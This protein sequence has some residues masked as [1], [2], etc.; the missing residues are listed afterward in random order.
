[1]LY[2]LQA[3]LFSAEVSRRDL[4][5]IPPSERGRPV[6]INVWRNHA[7]EAILPLMAPFSAIRAWHGEFNL[8]AYDDTL[9]F[10]G[11]RPADIELLWLDSS[12]FALAPD[13]PAWLEWLRSRL[14]VLRAMSRAPII[15]ATWLPDI[16]MRDALAAMTDT[17]PA[18]YFADLE[19]AC[20]D[21][22]IPLVDPR[23][24]KISGSPIS[25]RAQAHLARE[26]AC[27]WIPA[28]LFPP[29]KAVALDLD[30][31]L[32]AGIVGEDGIDGVRLTDGHVRLQNQLKN[33]R[34]HGVFI[35]LVSRNEYR[36]VEALFAQRLDYPLRWDDFSAIEVTWGDKADAIG[37]IAEH[38]RISTD[39]MLFVDDNLGE[40]N[41]VALKWPQLHT[42][43][44]DTD[45][46]ATWRAI[47]W[48]PGLWRW[49]VESDDTKRVQDLQANRD[50]EALAHQT[51]DI[52]DYFRMLQARLTYRIDPSDQLSRLADLC[53]KTNQFNLAIRRL[54]QA[55]LADRF[56]GKDTCVM[57]VQLSDRLSDSGVIALVAATRK[58]S[59]LIV[60]E[61]CVS[62]RAMG[63]RLENDIVLTALRN[64]PIFPGC[65]K[66][67]FSVQHGPRNKPALE[68]LTQLSGKQAAQGLHS[69]PATVVANFAPT[70]GV[71]LTIEGI[72]NNEP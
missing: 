43:Y 20:T 32:H 54:N 28:A 8:G 35:A 33:L 47:S 70:D 50:R 48:W 30:N 68:W 63:R 3:A 10:N 25:N 44:A 22:D 37:R 17:C 56:V 38:L 72:G 45:A 13:F 53:A 29:I 55:E 66:V 36:D 57:S 18:T 49:K 23:V 51:D 4:L 7:F 2:E 58:G 59:D 5:D 9:I 62:C 6:S 26:L 40:L 19:A 39:A 61:L 14:S 64:M 34:E 16:A 12:R 71:E 24:A 1:M 41:S 15:V 69:V 42:L 52:G 67:V 65:E 21:Q 46:D 27:R 31:T 60:E 11:W